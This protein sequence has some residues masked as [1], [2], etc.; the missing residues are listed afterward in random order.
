MRARG[1]NSVAQG[2][3]QRHRL[4][5]RGDLGRLLRRQRGA[6]GQADVGHPVDGGEL[7]SEPLVR[8]RV[9]R[10]QQLARDLAV[11]IF[12]VADDRWHS[13]APG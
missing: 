5:A 9:F 7:R 10:Q 13:A 12:S 2:V 6:V 3:G 8:C 1:L 11:D 4:H